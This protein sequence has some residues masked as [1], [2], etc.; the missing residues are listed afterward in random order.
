MAYPDVLADLMPRLKALRTAVDEHITIERIARYTRIL[1]DTPAP[2]S[3]ASAFRAP[4]LRQLLTED[5]ALGSTL[6]FH[7]DF[8][9]TGSAAILIGSGE[10]KPLWLFA[11]LDTISYLVQPRQGERYP[12]IPFCYHLVVDGVRAALLCRYDLRTNRYVIAAKGEMISEGGTPFFKPDNPGFAVRPGDRVVLHTPYRAMADGDFTGHV[13]NAGGVAAL[14][15]A[16]PVLAA[17]GVDAFLG[18]P[19]EEEGPRGEG[20]QVIGRGGSRLVQSMPTPE[21]TFIVDVQQ[22]GGDPDADTRGGAENSSRMGEGA[23]LA[24]FSSFARGSVTPPH[25]YGLAEALAEALPELGVLMQISN[26]AYTSRSDDI[27]V[28][29]KSPNILL[30]GFAGFNRHF[31]RREPKANIGD[32]THLAKALVYYAALLPVYRRL[33]AELLGRSA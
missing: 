3:A 6:S 11:H 30:L 7:P 2:S 27:S 20:N 21:L 12:L 10:S 9:D 5:G 26:N 16:A 14:A 25:L 4:V 15:V 13:D 28:M 31:D 22:G 17:A 23:V 32:I 1:A 29:L 33:K 24:E 8:K 18:F 19:D